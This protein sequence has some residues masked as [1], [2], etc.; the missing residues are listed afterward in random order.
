LIERG[1]VRPP[2][3]LNQLHEGLIRIGVARRFGEP[4]EAQRPSSLH[5][6][7]NVAERVREL[8]G[9]YES[10]AVEPD[11]LGSLSF[12]ERAGVR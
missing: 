6:T 4:F 9:F 2:R 8:L 3:D 10:P 5:E 12:E 7:E 1:F 11:V